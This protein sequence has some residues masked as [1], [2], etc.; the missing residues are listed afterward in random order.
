MIAIALL[1][2]SMVSMFMFRVNAEDSIT[3]TIS[4]YPKILNMNFTSKDN[5]V[6]AYITLPPEYN[7]TDIDLTTV[8]INGTV[9]VNATLPHF[10]NETTLMVNF[11]R[12]NTL[13]GGVSYYIFSQGIKNGTVT[14]NVSCQLNNGTAFEGVDVINA[15]LAGDINMDCHVNA[16]D[17]ALL[18]VALGHYDP[19]ADE[20][21]DGH[22]NV[23]DAVLLG[24]NFGTNY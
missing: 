1:S 19:A 23:K 21:E 18:G 12:G 4:I 10:A 6:T 7:A 15:R 14:L 8:K 13:A 2:L 24:R 5:N 22:I 9:P 11:N 20:N 17:A 3:A 16:S